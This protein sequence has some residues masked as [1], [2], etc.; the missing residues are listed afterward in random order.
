MPCVG[1]HCAMP[2]PEAVS[3]ERKLRPCAIPLCHGE[4]FDLVHKFPMDNERASAWLRMINVPELNGLP[5]DQLR[6][7]YFICSKHFR[8]IDYKNC[9]SRSLNQTAYPRLY[10]NAEQTDAAETVDASPQN[11]D[12]SS[13]SVDDKL[14]L[15]PENENPSIHV[16]NSTIASPVEVIDLESEPDPLL[17][18]DTSPVPV[19]MT[20]SIAP[21]TSATTRAA[22]RPISAKSG[23]TMFLNKHLQTKKAKQSENIAVF[24]IQSQPSKER[25]SCKFDNHLIIVAGL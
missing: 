8:K 24:T 22:K 25:Q 17:P 3:A 15:L 13:T 20:M 10:L 23:Q 1:Q 14:L 6:K 19:M 21:T 9:E 5:L 16:L 12:V 2:L 18:V 11:T 7:K 4:R